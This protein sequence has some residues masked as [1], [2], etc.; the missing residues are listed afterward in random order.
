MQSEADSAPSIVEEFPGPPLYYKDYYSKL[1]APPIPTVNPYLRAYNG[2][3]AHIHENAAHYDSE[4][5][6]KVEFK[7]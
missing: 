2:N 7:R 6:Y 3:F 1:T 4:K 5:D